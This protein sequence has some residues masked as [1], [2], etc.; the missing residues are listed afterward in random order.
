M[1]W[2]IIH[3][4]KTKWNRVELNREAGEWSEGKEE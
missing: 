1:E 2:N 3:W 4:N